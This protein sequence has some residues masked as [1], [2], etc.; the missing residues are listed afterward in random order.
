MSNRIILTFFLVVIFWLYAGTSLSHDNSSIRFIENK[1]Q[2]PGEVLFKAS[3]PGGDIYLLKN[4]LKYVLYQNNNVGHDGLTKSGGSALRENAFPVRKN[5]IHSVEVDFVGSSE[6]S[7]IYGKNRLS[8]RINYIKGKIP[9]YWSAGIRS[10]SELVIEGLYPGIDFSL[11]SS[12]GNIKYDLIVNPGAD[13]GKIRMRYEG[14]NDLKIHEGR[15][16]IGTA[17][18]YFMEDKPVSYSASG[19]RKQS[20]PTEF[21]QFENSVGFRFPTGYDNQTRLVI[22]PELIFSTYSGSFADNWGFTATYDDEGNLYSGGI[23][24]NVGYPTTSGVFQPT[25]IGEWDVG[26]LKY[27]PTGKNLIWATYLGGTFSETPQSLIVNSKGQ[28]VIYGTTSSPDFPMT[29]NSF[30]DTFLGGDP[31][32]DTTFNPNPRLVGG[33]PMFNGTDIFL[34]ILD[35]N[36]TS[37]IGSTFIGGTEND[38][39]MEKYMPLTKNYGDQFRGEVNLDAF[40][41]IYVASNTSSED[42]L[43][44]NGFQ[45]SYGGDVNDGVVMKFDP[46]LS[47]LYWSTFLGGS[48][49]DAIYSV[50]IDSE[51]NVFAAGGSNSMDFPITVGTIK[52]T[53][54]NAGDIDGVVV[55][56]SADGSTLEKATFLG[57]SSYDQVYILE[58][59]SSGQVYVLGQTEGDYLVTEGVYYN[60][61][62]GQFIHKI[63]S[64][65]DSTFFSTTIGSGSGTPDFSPTAFLVNECN[66]IFISGWGGLLNDPSF[67]YNGGYTFGLPVTSNAFQNQTDGDDFYLMVLL[68]DAK[69]LLYATYFGEIGGRGEHVD[70]GTSRFDKKGIVYQSVCGGCGGTSGFPTWPSDVWSTTN[71]SYNCNNAAFKFDLA[72]LMAQFETATE[73]FSLYGI[74]EGCYP[75]TLFFLNESIGGEDFLWEF[76]E[77]T[78]TD[79]EDSILITYENPGIYPIVLTA[80]DINTCVRESKATGIITV[81]DYHFEIM[82]ND[83]ICQGESIALNAEGGIH[84]DWKPKGNLTNPHTST[85]VATPDTTTVYSVIIEDENGCIG[86]DT[87]IIKVI[88]GIIADFDVE[89]MYDCSDT[90]F[91]SFANLSENA[92]DF[93]WDFGD[94]NVSEDA[95]P[96]HQYEPSDSIRTFLVAL[97]AGESFCSAEKSMWITSA[98]TFVPNF[99]SPNADGKN[100]VFEITA[101]GEVELHIYNR[102]GKEVFNM[103]NYQNNWGGEN[104]PS[105]IYFYEILFS[106]KNTRCNGWVHV[107]R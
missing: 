95:E 63:S 106:D 52:T 42:F 99:V 16:V 73:D 70:G 36:G 60:A 77:G 4:K 53:K 27:D 102:Y 107:L 96:T 74:R 91:I 104:L 87:L 59:D 1:G 24:F 100:D 38:G 28:L 45:V 85:P 6:T 43:V 97:T 81:H 44:K 26:I 64:D 67:G 19:L 31:I 25:H 71:N 3:M 75:L 50:K 47:E 13:P 88:P 55:K 61:N 7:T 58:L 92:S 48:G 30:Q 20:V 21:T 40:D 82:P 35:E 8:E 56:I 49:M 37:L 5:V 86:E 69:Q 9:D 32:Y 84:Y 62:G 79:Q 93:L 34:A 10:F 89:K 57:T 18:G 72:S 15:V 80:T 83:S 65:L 12:N 78:I 17:F 41:N 94:G 22:D 11:Y 76:G 46:I 14:Q 66:N 33:V 68:E 105:G 2:W 90:P 29:L 98:T 103:Y 101:D 39:V 51:G 54:P 23:V